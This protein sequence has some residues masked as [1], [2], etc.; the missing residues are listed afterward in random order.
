[1][2]FIIMSILT[3]EK[4]NLFVDE[5]M[6]L[7]QQINAFKPKNTLQALERFE[8]QLTLQEM[9]ACFFDSEPGELAINL[10]HLLSARWERIRNSNMC[11]TVQP[12]NLVNQLCLEI[13]KALS[14][15]AATV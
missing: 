5:I 6:D 10:T 2:A 7:Q 13:A 8:N 9:G 4:K 15:P 12:Q 3:S 14:P 1:M 11:Y